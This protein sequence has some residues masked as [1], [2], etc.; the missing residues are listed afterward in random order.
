[1]Q[2]FK[3]SKDFNFS[4][5]TNNENERTTNTIKLPILITFCFVVNLQQGGEICIFFE[6]EEI[7]NSSH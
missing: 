1:M 4:P 6:W 7:K 2:H 3:H 5:H